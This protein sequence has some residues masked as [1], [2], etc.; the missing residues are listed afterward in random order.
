MP[1]HI[2]ISLVWVFLQGTFARAAWAVDLSS[3][4]QNPDQLFFN[5]LVARVGCKNA[6]TALAMPKGGYSQF[7]KT[8]SRLEQEGLRRAGRADRQYSWAEINQR[9]FFDTNNIMAQ[10]LRQPSQRGQADGLTDLLLRAPNGLTILSLGG[11]GSQNVPTGSLV[12]ALES[13]RA[14]QPELFASGRVQFERIECSKSFLSDES[15][16]AQD[17]LSTINQIDAASPNPGRNKYLLWGY[18]KGGTTALEMLR[19]NPA[20]RERTL[21]VVTIGSPVQGSLVLDYLSPALDRLPESGPLSNQ[22]NATIPGGILPLIQLFTGGVSTTVQEELQTI[23]EAREGARTLTESY[24]AQYL[25]RNFTPN[26]FVRI[27]GSKI[28]VFQIAGLFDPKL[29]HPLPILTIRGGKMVQVDGSSNVKDR[30]IAAAILTAGDHPISDSCV[31]LEEA[32]LPEAVSAAAGLDTHFL[33]FIRQD[34]LGLHFN[35]PR[36]FGSSIS[37]DAAIVDAALSTIAKRLSP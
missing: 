12:G 17:M 24:R 15:F 32:L 16:C 28:P 25:A 36:S 33:A 5:E 11:F 26:K 21:A 2:L 27:D 13:W 4:T 22:I 19:Q 35:S 30:K 34:H 31:A 20:L 14:A 18:S 1:Y 6:A 10:C 3:V 29:L 37:T 23:Q 9:E 8:L 7:T